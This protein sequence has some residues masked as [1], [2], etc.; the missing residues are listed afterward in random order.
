MVMI[1]FPLTQRLNSALW[2]EIWSVLTHALIHAFSSLGT[3]MCPIPGS[4][5]VE[6]SHSV[7]QW[8]N[9]TQDWWLLIWNISYAW[10]VKCE[11]SFPVYWIKCLVR[12]SEV[13]H[14]NEVRG[15]NDWK[16]IYFTNKMRL[17]VRISKCTVIIISCLKFPA[18][19]IDFLSR[20]Y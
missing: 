20:F 9:G 18:K 17:S 15:N 4:V 2:Q 19:T 16:V 13:S 11:Q 3:V 5:N 6:K 14:L 12:N 1:F 10:E 8:K 7:D